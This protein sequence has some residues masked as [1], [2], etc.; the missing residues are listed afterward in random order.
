MSD[1]APA[2]DWT[3]P[4]LSN[5]QDPP[6]NRWA[7]SHVRDLIPVLPIARG[8]GP[9]LELGA[10]VESIGELDVALI[11]GGSASVSEIL[12]TTFTDGVVIVH[13]GDV[14]H[15]RYFGETA[16]DTPHLLMSVSKSMV[17]C[18]VGCLVD[19]G[20]L[21]PES[22]VTEYVPELSHSGYA[23]ARVRDLLDMRSGV[24]FSEAYTDPDGGQA[25]RE[26]AWLAT[27]RRRRRRSRC[28]RIS[29]PS[30]WSFP[31]VAPSGTGPVRP[32]CSAGSANRPRA[33]RWP[34]SS[35]ADLVAAGCRSRR[36][37][38]LRRHRR[39]RP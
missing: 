6:Y 31:T 38:L 36:R 26:G 34:S 30:L 27:E 24:R 1:T 21:A 12:E 35:R 29:R 4:T 13:D 14:V 18:V 15:E 7:F 17:S 3:R 20:L 25:D 37:N 19:Q 28:I 16:A 9:I 39:R 5:W 22:L 23:G 10:R 2:A 33:C 11:Q 8:H 32:T